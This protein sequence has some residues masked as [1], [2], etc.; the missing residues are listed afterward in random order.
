MRI[1]QP[2][3]LS[4]ERRRKILSLL[5]EQGRVTVNG[6]ADKF[7]ISAVT[8]RSDLEELGAKGLLV[9]SHGGAILPL[10]P[11]QEYPLHLKKTLHHL[12]KVRI[13]RA[14][15]Q[16]VQPRQT[17]I[18]DGGTTTAEAARALKRNSPEALTVIT[19]ALNIALELADSPNISLIMI[20]GVFRHVSRSFAGPPAERMMSDLHADHFFLGVDGLILNGTLHSGHARSATE[21]ADAPG[22][23]GSVRPCG[24]NE[25]WTAEPVPDRRHAEH[26]S[27]D[28]GQPGQP[29]NGLPAPP[30]GDRSAC[31]LKK[32][33]FVY[34]RLFTFSCVAMGVPL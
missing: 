31:R 2:R 17:V 27:G 12:E 7:H 24:C 16:L 34:R 25:V 28:H 21:H 5:E 33:P 15:A 13:G 22:S 32:C 6:L 4:E 1:K 19:H 18:I 8:I 9:R 14:A 20:G 29:G 11:Q 23:Q 26:P 10:S 30:D 3:L